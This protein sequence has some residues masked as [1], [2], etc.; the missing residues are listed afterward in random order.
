MFMFDVI[1]LLLRILKGLTAEGVLIAFM[2]RKCVA[3]FD[4]DIYDIWKDVLDHA[5]F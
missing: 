1:A 2:I 5:I 3:L 4:L